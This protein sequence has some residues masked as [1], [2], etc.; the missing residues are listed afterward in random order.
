MSGPV[1]VQPVRGDRDRGGVAVALAGVAV[2]VLLAGWGLTATPPAAVV[3][4]SPEPS[5]IPSADAP[6]IPTVRGSADGLELAAAYLDWAPCPVWHGHLRRGR[7]Q[8]AEVVAAAGWLPREGTTAVLA[9]EHGRPARVFIGHAFAEAAEAWEATVAFEGGDRARWILTR[10]GEVLR[11]AEFSAASGITYWQVVD[12]A[13]PMPWC[14]SAVGQEG[15]NPATGIPAV[16]AAPGSGPV[17]LAARGGWSSCA[18]ARYSVVEAPSGDRVDAAA[19]AAGVDEGWVNPEGALVW[20][21]RDPVDLGRAVGA[22]LVAVGEAD[23]GAAWV[24]LD[25]RGAPYGQQ[26]RRIDTPAGRVAWLPTANATG[27]S[28]ATSRWFPEGVGAPSPSP[29]ASG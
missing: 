17:I 16:A 1:R 19:V 22:R 24:L 8:P 7:A 21:G 14:A 4:P 9:D 2:V 23:G 11:L 28:C 15:P 10:R 12:E 6:G 13:G 20:L 3:A 29:S 25:V 26:V 27:P 18:W 5:P